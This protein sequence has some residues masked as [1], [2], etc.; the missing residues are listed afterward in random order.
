MPLLLFLL[1][2]S[3]GSHVLRAGTDPTSDAGGARVALP[4][5]SDVACDNSDCRALVAGSLL[6][7]PD[8]TPVGTAGALAAFDV[9]RVTSAGWEVEGACGPDAQASAPR[10]VAPLAADGTPGT[11]V[12]VPTLPPALE[13]DT[14]SF[15]AAATAFGAAWNA[16]I[17]AGWRSGFHRVI[18][19]PGGGRITW[20]RGIDGAGQLVRAGNG[21]RTVRLGAATASVSWPGWLALHPTGVEAY[22]VAWPSPLVRAFDPTTLDLR[23]TLPVDG[24]ARGLFVDPGGRWLLVAV[25]PGTTERLVEWSLPALTPTP[26]ADLARDEVLRAL[27]HPP[28]EETLVIDLATHTVAARAK[29]EL[30][31]FLPLPDRPLLA[32]DAEIVYVTPGALP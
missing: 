9:L 15:S 26:S 17:A 31:R 18:V 29:G 28:A 16:G 4:G 11:P 3:G 13:E 19:G 7:L 30:R 32:T 10:C 22:L 8:A 24:A 23:W 14:P 1:A 12:P 5:L 2:C 21:S 27:D 20:L 25:G 6:S